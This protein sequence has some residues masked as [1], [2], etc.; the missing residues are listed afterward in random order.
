MCSVRLPHSFYFARQDRGLAWRIDCRRLANADLTPCAS[1]SISC[2]I[3]D[4][5]QSKAEWLHRL[6]LPV[7]GAVLGPT[8]LGP[9]RYGTVPC[10][11][12][13]AVLQKDSAFSARKTVGTWNEGVI[14]EPTFNRFLYDVN[15][16]LVRRLLS[17]GAETCACFAVFTS[18]E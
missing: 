8:R 2:H 17:R 11:Q 3:G 1:H 16:L 13:R 9:T 7:T 18:F 4:K 6:P 15:L 14:D 10:P 12:S 5:L